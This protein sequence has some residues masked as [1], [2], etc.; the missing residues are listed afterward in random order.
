MACGI[1]RAQ[2]LSFRFVCPRR[3]IV[4]GQTRVLISLYDTIELFDSR[5]FNI[6]LQPKRSNGAEEIQDLHQA[7]PISNL[8]IINNN[9]G[10]VMR[11]AILTNKCFRNSDSA[12]RRHVHS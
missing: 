8:I 10:F 6:S 12:R 11:L 4:P 2:K 5:D 7:M 1:G 3:K 9:L